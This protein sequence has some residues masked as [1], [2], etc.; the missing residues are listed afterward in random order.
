MS[1]T[2]QNNVNGTPTPSQAPE[3]GHVLNGALGSDSQSPP[4]PFLTVQRKGQTVALSREQAQALASKGF[5]YEQKTSELARQREEVAPFL[6]LRSQAEKDPVLQR[7]LHAAAS[8]PNRVLRALQGGPAHEDTSTP[9]T[10]ITEG[11]EQL[12]DRKLAP[13]QQEL[14]SVRQEKLTNAR[15][16]AVE[17]AISSQEVLSDTKAGKQAVKLLAES[18]MAKDRDLSPVEAVGMA[19]SIYTDGLRERGQQLL[20]KN[21]R[22]APLKT[23]NPNVGTPPTAPDRAPFDRKAMDTGKVSRRISDELRRPGVF[24]K[25]FGRPK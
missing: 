18:F 9:E 20:D 16:H 6:Q 21:A 12:L 7:A 17:Q 13:M 22:Q 23:Q 15:E 3:S 4:E 8:D 1:D 5:D 19:T 11:V 24:E 25:F 14:Q 10:N 2:I